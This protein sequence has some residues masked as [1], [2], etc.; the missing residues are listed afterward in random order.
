M[1]NNIIF[2]HT[3]CTVIRIIIIKSLSDDRISVKLRV[4]E[5]VMSY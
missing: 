4:T 2:L 5:K 3:Y 1:N